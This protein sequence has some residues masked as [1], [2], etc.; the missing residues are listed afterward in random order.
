MRD[1]GMAPSPNNAFLLISVSRLCILE[2]SDT[3]EMPLAVAQ[4]LENINRSVG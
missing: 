4:Y 2:W 3:A 1:M